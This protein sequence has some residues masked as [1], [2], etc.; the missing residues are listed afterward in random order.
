M[1]GNE[2]NIEES[3]FKAIMKLMPVQPSQTTKVVEQKANM[4][5]AE[6]EEGE[7]DI[8]INSASNDIIANNSTK[9][10][11]AKIE[12]AFS[13]RAKHTS[14]LIQKLFQVAR[15]WF[16]NQKVVSN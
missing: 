6:V 12:S 14:Y 11:D 3:L 1:L 8:A 9:I 2:K 13:V 5:K 7:L 10:D 15:I 16:Q 4:A